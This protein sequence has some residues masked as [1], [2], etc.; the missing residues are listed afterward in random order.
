MRDNS[1]VQVELRVAGPQQYRRQFQVV[2]SWA[3]RQ[4][5][6]THI[7]PLESQEDATA[8]FD[9]AVGQEVRFGAQVVPPE[10]VAARGVAASYHGTKEITVPFTAAPATDEGRARKTA[11]KLLAEWFYRRVGHHKTARAIVEHAAL[12][13]LAAKQAT[14]QAVFRIDADLEWQ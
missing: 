7:F 11:R 3:G 2:T 4:D 13:E 10:R 8:R 1:A 12:V 9:R 6:D 14:W 5:H